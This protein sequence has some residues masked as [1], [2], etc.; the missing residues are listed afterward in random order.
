MNT[1]SQQSHE[2]RIYKES[3][4]F[5]IF[6][7]DTI[8]SSEVKILKEWYHKMMPNYE[9]AEVW[10]DDSIEPIKWQDSKL[11]RL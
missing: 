8:E 9:K 4:R 10:L 6:Q 1:Q 5:D 3:N 7:K 2:V 11:G